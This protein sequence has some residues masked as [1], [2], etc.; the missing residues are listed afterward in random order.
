MKELKNCELVAS[1]KNILYSK[2]AAMIR[3]NNPH[4]PDLFE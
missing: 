2:S 1:R 4:P 3:Y